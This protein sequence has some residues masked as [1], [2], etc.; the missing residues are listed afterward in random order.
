MFYRQ[1]STYNDITKT[2]L[3]KH[4]NQGNSQY[5]FVPFNAFTP[6]VN[7]RPTHARQKY[8]NYP[9]THFRTG[10]THSKPHNSIKPYTRLLQPHNILVL[11]AILLTVTFLR[12]K[13]CEVKIPAKTWI[14]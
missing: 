2:V 1:S 11:C 12:Y 5:I 14:F 4:L 6:P 7:Q 8:L 3:R 13:K 9:Q 10:L